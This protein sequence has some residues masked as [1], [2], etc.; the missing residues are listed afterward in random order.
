METIQ[1]Q[2]CDNNVTVNIPEELKQKLDACGKLNRGRFAYVAK[3][4]SGTAGIKGC[5]RPFVSNILF[6][7]NP[8]YDLYLTRMKDAISKINGYSDLEAKVSENMLKTIEAKSKDLNADFQTAKSNLIERLEKSIA[9]DASDPFRAA[10]RECYCHYNGWKLHLITEKKEDGL[11]RP[12]IENN[13]MTIESIMLPFFETRRDPAI[14]NENGEYILGEWTPTNSRSL[15]LMQDAIKKSTGLPEWKTISLNKNNF[16]HLSL[17]AKKIYSTLRD[18]SEIAYDAFI[19]E[20]CGLPRLPLETLANEA[21]NSL[22]V[23]TEDD[24]ET[25][26]TING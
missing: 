5:V 4:V 12:V 19:A 1:V 16:S 6:T 9:G 23:P 7:R 11:K 25:N 10:A 13:S 21:E 17:D 18:T 15:T 20:I 8:R 3:H 2:Y 24:S 26:A 22:G 14:K